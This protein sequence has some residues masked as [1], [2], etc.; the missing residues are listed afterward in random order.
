MKPADPN[1]WDQRTDQPNLKK[2]AP[3]PELCG[4]ERSDEVRQQRVVIF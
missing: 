1:Q 3:N 2:S 4:K